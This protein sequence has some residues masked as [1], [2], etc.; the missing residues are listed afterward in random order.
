VR[1]YFGHLFKFEGLT[2]MFGD[3]VTFKETNLAAAINRRIFDPDD[4]PSWAR[5]L[6]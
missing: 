6:G 4:A 3:L 5:A 1:K 2:K